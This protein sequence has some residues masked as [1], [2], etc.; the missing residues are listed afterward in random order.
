MR[1]DR[2]RVSAISQIGGDLYCQNSSDISH[3]QQSLASCQL[4]IARGL[5]C[6]TDDRLR[7]AVIQQLICNFHLCFNEIE[8][9]FD[10]QFRQYFSM[11]WPQ[12]EQMAH[13]DLITPDSHGIEVTPAGRLVVRALC[14][15]FDHYLSEQ[16]RQCFSQLI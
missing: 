10:V 13:D 12:M 6:N 9:R 1:P 3:Y 2:P 4:G 8:M 15:L 14:M 16:S 11:L 5:Q 7:R